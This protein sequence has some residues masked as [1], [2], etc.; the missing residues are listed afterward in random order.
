MG[1]CSLIVESD[2]AD[3]LHLLQH[4]ST[5]SGPFDQLCGKDWTIAFS[6]VDRHNNEVADQLAKFASIAT[7]DVVTFDEPPS[8]VIP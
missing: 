8:E 7:F 1:C 3:A 2:S 6:K 5:K 4:R